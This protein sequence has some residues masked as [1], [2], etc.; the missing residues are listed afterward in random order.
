MSKV[1]L[2]YDSLEVEQCEGVK[3]DSEAIELA[4][5][6]ITA[7]QLESV[8]RLITTPTGSPGIMPILKEMTQG[9]RDD[10]RALH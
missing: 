10:P 5:F 4:R 2:L 1:R 7:P 9:K 6:A 3:A 8:P